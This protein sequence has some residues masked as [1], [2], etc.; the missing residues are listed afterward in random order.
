MVAM[1]IFIIIYH[2]MLIGWLLS[3]LDNL[4]FN[5]LNVRKGW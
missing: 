1:A 5:A 4:L 2:Q 3:W